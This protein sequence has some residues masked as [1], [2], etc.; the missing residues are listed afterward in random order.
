MCLGW[1]GPACLVGR[2]TYEQQEAQDQLQAC[3]DDVA[4][5]KARI[6]ELQAENSIPALARRERELADALLEGGDVAIVAPPMTSVQLRHAI[7]VLEGRL[8]EALDHENQARGAVRRAKLN[9]MRELLIQERQ[10]YDDLAKA[11]QHQWLRVTVLTNELDAALGMSTLAA[12][13]FRLSMPRGIEPKVHNLFEDVS[14]YPDARG[15]LSATQ[16][17]LARKEIAEQLQ[18]EGIQ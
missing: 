5:I 7:G 13:W 6:A 4:R 16:G 18:K 17:N 11:T 10:A 1:L 2:P 12:P 14:T 9:R 3:T 15:L 8:A